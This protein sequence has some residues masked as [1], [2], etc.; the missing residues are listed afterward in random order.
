[1]SDDHKIIPADLAPGRRLAP[2]VSEA[3]KQAPTPE[4]IAALLDVQERWEAGEAKKAF[5]RA[6]VALKRSLPSTIEKDAEVDFGKG[7][8]RT[9]YRHSTLAAVMNLVDEHLPAHGF[10]LSWTTA[11][12]ERGVITVTCRLMHEDGHSEETSLASQPDTSGSKGPAQAIASTTTYLKR[13][14]AMAL[15]GLASREETEP[16]GPRPDVVDEAPPEAV[17]EKLNRAAAAKLVRFGLTIHAA[18]ELVGRSMS[19]WTRADLMTIG[20]W[21]TEQRREP[22]EE[23]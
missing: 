19:D 2:V 12:S 17:N 23:G 8:K 16:H 15:L 4:T 6:L 10:A 14:T 1:M 18:E 20:D 3:L 21:V 11:Q 7:E 22:G 5:A 9:Y 13:Y